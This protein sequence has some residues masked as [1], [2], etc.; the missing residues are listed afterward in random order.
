MTKTTLRRAALLVAA[1]VAVAAVPA[2]A[3]GGDGLLPLLKP[4]IRETG[5]PT[6][7]QVVQH[8][9]AAWLTPPP[10]VVVDGVEAGGAEALGRIDAQ[11]VQ[12]VQ[13]LT[14]VQAA[15]HELRLRNAGVPVLMVA[16][17]GAPGPDGTS[18][19]P[20]H[21]GVAF[22]VYPYT[23]QASGQVN[24]WQDVGTSP[25]WS[26]LKDDESA[27]PSAMA[28]LR[29]DIGPRWHAELLGARESGEHYERYTGAT[30]PGSMRYRHYML[31]ALA[32]VSH[33]MLRVAAGPMVT[34]TSYHFAY[35]ECDCSPRRPT[36]LEQYGALAS[37]AATLPGYRSVFPELRAQ[38]R[39]ASK[40]TLQQPL[41]DAPTSETGGTSV[42]LTA[43]IGVGRRR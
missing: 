18:P 26:T 40:Y 42:V 25:G 28:A 34:M 1:A 41:V 17:V 36:K 11:R 20:P 39:H 13:Y 7:Y 32:G 19:G 8:L 10:V 22:T 23:L 9:R 38:V 3:Q 16:M 14:P 4:Q 30:I 12:S 37:V 24:D 27:P 6:L 35:G 43:G 5:Y 15:E 2:R 31:A 33:G 29:F 21:V